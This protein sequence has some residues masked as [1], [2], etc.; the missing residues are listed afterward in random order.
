[1]S[2]INLA[3]SCFPGIR[4]YLSDRAIDLTPLIEDVAANFYQLEN[5]D[6]ALWVARTK[7]EAARTAYNREE[8]AH[9]TLRGAKL[10]AVEA[11]EKAMLRNMPLGHDPKNGLYLCCSSNPASPKYDKKAVECFA[12][13]GE[14]TQEYKDFPCHSSA[15]TPWHLEKEVELL[16]SK[17]LSLR[18]ILRASEEKLQQVKAQT[19][20]ATLPEGLE[21]LTDDVLGKVLEIVVDDLDVA[22]EPEFQTNAEIAGY[23]RAELPLRCSCSKGF[24]FVDLKLEGHDLRMLLDNEPRH[25]ICRHRALF[26]PAALSGAVAEKHA[27]HRIHDLKPWSRSPLSIADQQKMIEKVPSLLRDDLHGWLI[28]GPA[29]GSKT[30]V[31]SAATYDWL[32]FRWTGVNAQSRNWSKFDAS[33]EGWYISLS[34]RL[35]FW[36]V[37]VPK[38]TRD[39]EAWENRDFKDES[40]QEPDVTTERLEQVTRD[41]YLR[42]ILVLEELDKFNP[43]T[44]R[45]RFLHALVDAVYESGGCIVSTANETPADLEKQ[46]GEPLYRRLSGKYD[47]PEH[48]L[49]WNMFRAGKRTPKRA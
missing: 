10:A 40:T 13:L 15:D 24:A 34:K 38:W 49:L 33:A 3:L 36:R 37:K 46:L 42:P 8:A 41:T 5:L 1:M 4:R 25:D 30:T 47:A 45:L 19:E 43:T 7:A 23:I 11:A 22:P 6:A 17:V 16:A 26:H 20:G 44:N 28:V 48:Y 18:P 21:G 9:K 32:T 2:P 12:R 31:V 29:G 35:N 27:V 14:L 39:T